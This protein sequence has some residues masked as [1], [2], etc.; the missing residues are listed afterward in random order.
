MLPGLEGDTFT[1]TI[2]DSQGATATAQVTVIV[3]PIN[4]APTVV[5][6]IG[7]VEVPVEAPVPAPDTVLDLATTFT[8]VDI[9]T[10][11]DALTLRLRTNTNPSLVEATLVET[12]LRLSYQRNQHGTATLTVQ[13]T[14][15]T[16][17]VA[18]DSFDV[19]VDG[20]FPFVVNVSRLNDLTQRLQRGE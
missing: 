18:E 6:P 8:D 11:A 15:Q 7:N 3:T 17:L 4:D 16:G 20:T 1:Y 9:A 14:D 13:A 2:S 12:T 10:N 19:T 5:T